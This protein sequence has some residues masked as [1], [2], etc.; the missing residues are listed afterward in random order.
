M[1]RPGTV[2][3]ASTLPAYFYVTEVPPVGVRV[4]FQNLQPTAEAPDLPVSPRA[5]ELDGKRVFIKGY[6]YPDG[7]QHNIKDF[8]L[9]RDM[10]TCCFGGQP[11]LTHMVAVRLR[12]PNRIEYSFRKRRLGGVF[13][14]NRNLRPVPGLGGVYFELDADYVR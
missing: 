11:P 3:G 10:G 14:V 12:D 6:V 8:I 2:V 7:Q 4:S 13:R 5:L 1:L 9:V